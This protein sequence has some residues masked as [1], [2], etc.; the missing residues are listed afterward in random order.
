MSIVLHLNLELVMG[1]DL[2][3][4]RRRERQKA[5][6][7]HVETA[8]LVTADDVEGERRAVPGGI[9]VLHHEL[10]DGAADG[11]TLLQETRSIIH[12]FIQL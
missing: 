4:E 11:L 8:V 12:T 10:E 2:L 9:S 6:L 5:A 7:V 1:L 3:P